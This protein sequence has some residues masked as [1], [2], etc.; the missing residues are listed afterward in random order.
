MSTVD[1]TELFGDSLLIQFGASGVTRSASIVTLD[2]GVSFAVAGLALTAETPSRQHATVIETFSSESQ[3]RGALETLVTRMEHH[4]RSR[5]LWRLAGTI[6]KWIG[7]PASIVVAMSTL[8]LALTRGTPMAP[9]APQALMAA[10]AIAQASE[11]SP[12]QPAPRRPLQDEL[13]RAMADGAKSGKFSVTL[14]KAP[15]GTLY[16]FS[17]P[18]CPHCQ[19]FENELAELGKTFTVHVFPVSAIGGDASKSRNSHALCASGADRLA[20]WTT[21]VASR[22]VAGAD[23]TLGRAAADANDTIFAAMRFSGTPTIISGTGVIFPDNIPNNA[24]SV[25]QWMR[26]TSSS[27]SP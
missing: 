22:D 14:S 7:I 18:L 15:G 11:P 17:D 13:A 21:I 24:A 5:Y 19:R 3:A 10:P 23:C 6:T 8:N 9:S 2:H 1:R 4:I 20:L 27:T 26:E 25:S 16:V 12:R